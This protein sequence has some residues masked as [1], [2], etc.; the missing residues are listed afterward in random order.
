[1]YETTVNIFCHLSF[2]TCRLCYTCYIDCLYGIFSSKYIS[3]QHIFLYAH[4]P[5]LFIFHVLAVVST[6][7]ITVNAI[8]NV[9]LL[10]WPFFFFFFISLRPIFWFNDFSFLDIRVAAIFCVMCAIFS[11]L[12]IMVS[13]V[14]LTTN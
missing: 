2:F 9:L 11:I 6:N 4:I 13:S 1:M 7:N 8:V 10:C 14:Y 5:L 12:F 3:C